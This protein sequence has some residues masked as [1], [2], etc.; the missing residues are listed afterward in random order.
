MGDGIFRRTA[1][2]A[3]PAGSTVRKLCCQGCGATLPVDS[4]VRFLTCNYCHSRLEV[5]RDRE[6]THTKV[7]DELENRTGRIERK[8]DA[9]ELRSRLSEL[10]AAWTRYRE[11]VSSRDRAGN[12]HP[13]A[14]DL[15]FGMIAICGVVVAVLAIL[16]GSENPFLGLA[17]A[18]AGFFVARWCWRSQSLKVRS[19][20]ASRARYEARRENLL[21]RIEEGLREDKGER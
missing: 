10:D 6:T 3:G 8:L 12:S 17:L 21:K 11:S 4:E 16:A 18:A 9:I 15:V 13:P 19:Y 5:V 20:E 14:M 1:N 7:L 2:D